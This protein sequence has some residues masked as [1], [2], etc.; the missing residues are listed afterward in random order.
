MNDEKDK[1]KTCEHN[2]DSGTEYCGLCVVGIKSN[3]LEAGWIKD[4][5]IKALEHDKQAV[6]D[7]LEQV[8]LELHQ[9]K[10]DYSALELQLAQQS[11][12]AQFRRVELLET[13]LAQ[14]EAE[15]KVLRY[16]TDERVAKILELQEQLEKAKK[17]IED[18]KNE[19][20]ESDK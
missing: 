6:E 19:I 10:T 5:K 11:H 7:A 12:S 8:G 15:N 3:W 4:K 14:L 18:L 1:C 13:Q 20:K 2:N 9:L 17:E 16:G